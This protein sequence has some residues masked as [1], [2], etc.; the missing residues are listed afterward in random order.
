[1]A[2]FSSVLFGTPQQTKQ[3]PLF[4]PEQLQA[5]QGLRQGAQ[6]Q[7]QATPLSFAPQRA[8]YEKHFSEQVI[9]TLAE[10]FAGNLR[11]SAFKG[12]LGNTTSDFQSKLAALESQYNLGANKQALEQLRL[13]L[14]PEYQRQTT[15]GQPGIFGNIAKIGG[16]ALGKYLGGDIGQAIGNELGQGVSSLFQNINAPNEEDQNNP[17]A[18]LQ[19]IFGSL[20][21]PQSKIQQIMSILGAA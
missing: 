14:S 19:Q 16:S 17:L 3:V 20:N 10:R 13:G 12:A 9:P 1:M 7:L 4:S 8:Q 11:S 5:R 21:L 6:Q 18:M 15:P 2:N